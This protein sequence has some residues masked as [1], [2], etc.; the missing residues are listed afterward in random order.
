MYD[1]SNLRD[2][3]IP[4]SDQLN[5]DQLLG[6]NMTVTVTSVS[7]GTPDQPVVINFDGDNGRPYKPCKSMRKVLIFA[8]GEDGSQWVGRSMTLFNKPDVKFGGVTVGGI[9]IS[10][11]SH[12]ERDIALSLASTKGKKEPYTIGR[13]EVSE[14]AA[15]KQKRQLQTVAKTQGLDAFKAAW[16]ALTKAGRKSLGAAFRDQCAASA[17]AFDDARASKV[18]AEQPSPAL[19][20]LNAAAAVKAATQ[21][22][23]QPTTQAASDGDE[24]FN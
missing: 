11:L 21:A 9:R 17:Q 2:T 12:I 3:I 19:D 4:K 13:L 22:V 23:T 24:I 16:N 6:G 7:R 1:V 15:E 8:W 18:E 14:T 10:H 20:A 5:S